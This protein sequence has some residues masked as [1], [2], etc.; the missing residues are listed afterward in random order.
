MIAEIFV[1]LWLLEIQFDSHI[2]ISTDW[3]VN[4]FQLF[5]A[6]VESS[7]FY[8]ALLKNEINDI[9]APQFIAGNRRTWSIFHKSDQIPLLCVLLFF[10]F[11][12]FI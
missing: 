9:F 6:G 3:T 12:H 10:A 11:T 2:G 1:H 8:Q 5:K 7:L 4:F